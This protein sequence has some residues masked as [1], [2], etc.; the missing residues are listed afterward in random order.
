MLGEGALG[1][2]VEQL[3]DGLLLL[4]REYRFLY[5][6]AAARA[7]SRVGP[8]HFTGKTHWELYP[9]SVGTVV[10]RVYRRVMETRVAEDLED[11]FYAPFNLWVRVKVLP[12]DGGIALFYKDVTEEQRNK[13]QR[14]ISDERV[15]FALEAANG[16]GTWDWD[17]NRNLVYADEGFAK[18]YGVDAKRA[19][20]GSPLEEFTSNMHPGDRERV[21]EEIQRALAN[22]EEF[23]SEYRITQQ[24]GSV[25]WVAARGRARRMGEEFRFP[26]ITFDI[27]DRKLTEDALIRSEKLAAVGRM[28]SSIAHEINNPLESVM[29]LLYL[30]RQA[31]IL[32]EVQGY[33]DL[34]ELELRRV[35]SIANQTLRFHKQATRPMEITAADL[36]STVLSLYEG[37]LKNSHIEVEKRLRAERP[38]ACFEG[39][40]RQ[41]LNNLVGNA[42][43]AM[44]TGGRLLIRSREGTDWRTEQRGLVLTVGD[45]G[46][47]I[48]RENQRHVFEA[49]FT[50]KGFAGTGLGLWVSQEIVERHGGRLRLRSRTDDSGHGAEHG[51]GHGTVATV[52][53]PFEALERTAQSRA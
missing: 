9:E 17:V 29:N 45:T 11:F 14:R 41:V 6:N 30:A 5:A 1:Q 37:R 23:A 31:A 53:L 34:A 22:G 51:T 42:I 43:D 48:S 38:V 39:D 2:V 15:H 21:G 52:F 20:E 32:P 10:E 27:T 49:F 44:P 8:E 47:G 36:Y 13:E 33:L 40:I 24:D 4:D 28:A 18:I 35:S 26:G 50:T 12:F 16:V 25:R 46:A 19:R 7:I 3:P